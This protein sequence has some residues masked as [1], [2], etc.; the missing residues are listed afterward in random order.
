M[1]P[2]WMKPE[3]TDTLLPARG[4]VVIGYGNDLRGDDAIGP[5]VAEEVARWNL[6]GVRVVLAHQL[7]PE[8]ADDLASADNAIFV[9]AR[10]GA[11]HQGVLIQTL[12]AAGNA[13]AWFHAPGPPDVLALAQTVFGRSPN[14]WL[15]TI[16]GRSFE[17]G[18]PPTQEALRCIPGALDHIRRLLVDFAASETEA[19]A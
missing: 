14:A 19:G 16:P 2:W 12:Q 18:E 6:P 5:R 17:L 7:T 9:D 4:S 13:D 8:L 3:G 10:I 15:V 1:A 11:E